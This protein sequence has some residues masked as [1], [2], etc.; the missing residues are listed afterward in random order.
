MKSHTKY[1]SQK[2]SL[3]TY[4]HLK[5]LLPLAV[6]MSDAS[7]FDKQLWQY[8]MIFWDENT[9]IHNHA[10]NYKVSICS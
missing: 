3:E 10:S 9:N 8:D 5:P 6:I 4:Q 2:I 7:S 1:K